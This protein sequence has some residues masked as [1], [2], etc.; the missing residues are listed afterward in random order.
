MIPPRPGEPFQA[1]A[2]RV[3][4][5]TKYLRIDTI[6]QQHILPE[7]RECKI[8]ILTPLVGDGA[9]PVQTVRARP[10]ALADFTVA[11]RLDM[12]ARSL[13][14]HPGIGDSPFATERKRGEKR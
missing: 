1:T 10:G 8:R 12:A 2:R 6:A 5:G 3:Q 4:A 7:T 14:F 9:K 13:Q 11:I